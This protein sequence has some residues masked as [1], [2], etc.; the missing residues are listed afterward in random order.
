MLLLVVLI[1]VM[2]TWTRAS[3]GFFS[4]EGGVWELL[5]HTEAF[6]PYHFSCFFFLFLPPLPPFQ[7]G[8]M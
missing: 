7:Q 4:G 1:K 2:V 3:C 8:L 5:Y 6:S